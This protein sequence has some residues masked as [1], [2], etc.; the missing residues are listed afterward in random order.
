LVIEHH[1]AAETHPEGFSWG[2]SSLSTSATND[3]TSNTD[4]FSFSASG[5]A[6]FR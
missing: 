6:T 1:G 4:E 3:C 5:A 2:E